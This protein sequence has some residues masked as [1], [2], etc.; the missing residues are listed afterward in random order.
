VLGG[1]FRLS[2]S[3]AYLVAVLFVVKMFKHKCQKV[4]N[5]IRF[6][7][8]YSVCYKNVV[9]IQKFSVIRNSSSGVQC[10]T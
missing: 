7:S 8:L 10:I 2:R 3:D 9:V 1:A 4:Q 6:L 5:Y